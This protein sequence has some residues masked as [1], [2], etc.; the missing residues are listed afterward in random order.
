MVDL[1]VFI[2]SQIF[3]LQSVLKKQIVM[4]FRISP[5]MSFVIFMKNI[6]IFF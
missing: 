2:W 6:I 5:L 3:A 1:N 4:S